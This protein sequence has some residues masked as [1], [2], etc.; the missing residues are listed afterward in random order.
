MVTDQH[1]E[2]TGNHLAVSPGGHVANVVDGKITPV[3]NA[4]VDKHVDP[5]LGPRPAE[6]VVK[7]RATDEARTPNPGGREVTDRIDTAG[8]QGSSRNQ[9]HTA[10]DA[11]AKVHSDG[12]LAN[13]VRAR[14]DNDPIYRGSYVALAGTRDSYAAPTDTVDEIRLKDA[15]ASKAFT[16]THEVGHYLDKR[17]LGQDGME[18]SSRG[19]D[20]GRMSGPEAE[21]MQDFLDAA[22]QSQALQEI[23]AKADMVGMPGYRAYLESP[24]EM[25]ARG[26][27]QFIATRSQD[28][29]MMGQLRTAQRLAREI[30]TRPPMQ[31]QDDDFAPVDAAIEKVLQAK[32]WMK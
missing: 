5:H 22:R 6:P 21:A 28:P 10:L 27:A 18:F 29:T 24:H 19:T 32:G 12:D 23:A 31:W 13:D 4:G 30:G 9:A 11:I 14:S 15:G 1:L 3:S 17:G 20:Q 25:W 16:F 7:P 8:L 26:Y 2:L